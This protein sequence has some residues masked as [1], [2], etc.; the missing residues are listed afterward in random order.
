MSRGP[1]SATHPGIEGNW[2]RRKS[3]AAPEV[4]AG[5]VRPSSLTSA[6][7]SRVRACEKYIFR[8][9]PMIRSGSVAAVES[10]AGP[11]SAPPARVAAVVAAAIAQRDSYSLIWATLSFE[12]LV[13]SKV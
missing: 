13:G 11:V 7:H 4:T 6:A 1:S 10:P 3:P 5:C 9:V 8:L 12:A 2:G